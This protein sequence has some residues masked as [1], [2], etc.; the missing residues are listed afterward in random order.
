[1]QEVLL[2][3]H[4]LNQKHRTY[5]IALLSTHTFIPEFN[6]NPLLWATEQLC[7]S[8]LMKCCDQM[9]P[10]CRGPR[11]YYLFFPCWESNW[12]SSRDRPSLL[13]YRQG[14]N[15]LFWLSRSELLM[16][17]TFSCRC[18]AGF[19]DWKDCERHK[20]YLQ[21][22]LLWTFTYTSQNIKAAQELAVD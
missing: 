20:K 8:Q 15:K 21:I 10:D 19:R 11:H 7:W 5:C 18:V 14:K 2:S 17:K 9:H 16:L 3:T 6:H 1:M 22:Q 12:Q 4:A 13:I